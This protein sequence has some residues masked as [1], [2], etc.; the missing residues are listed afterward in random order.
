[1][2]KKQVACTQRKWLRMIRKLEELLDVLGEK[3]VKLLDVINS[4]VV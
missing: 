2:M 4:V 1:M 3:V